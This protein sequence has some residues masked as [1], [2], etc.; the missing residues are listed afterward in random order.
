MTTKQFSSKIL[1]KKKATSLTPYRLCVK[2][3]SNGIVIKPIA[4][5]GISCIPKYK[6]QINN[7]KAIFLTN[8]SVDMLKRFLIRY[9]TAEKIADTLIKTNK[10]DTK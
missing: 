4:T 7:Q 3:Y 5:Q 1:G 2:F 10:E 8:E 9:D 6:E